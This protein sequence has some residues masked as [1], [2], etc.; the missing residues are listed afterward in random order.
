M[1][2]LTAGHFIYIYDVSCL[3]FLFVSYFWPVEQKS[4]VYVYKIIINRKRKQRDELDKSGHKYD[5][6]LLIFLMLKVLLDCL[7]CCCCCCILMHYTISH[8]HTHT[9]DL[10]KNVSFFPNISFH[11]SK[12]T[13]E[14]KKLAD[15]RKLMVRQKMKRKIECNN[16]ITSLDEENF[17]HMRCLFMCVHCT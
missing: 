5:E 7:V 6:L 1:C 4:N 2:P 3:F 8:T 15:C 16:V 9:L 12:R 10:S 17:I 13:H 14:E 11:K